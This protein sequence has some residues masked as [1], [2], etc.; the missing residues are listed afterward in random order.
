[1]F[2]IRLK[3]KTPATASLSLTGRMLSHPGCVRDANEDVVAY[4]LPG[5]GDRGMLALVADGM[6]G[7]AAG[8]VASRIAADTVMRMY[9]QLDGS[10]PEVFAA[11]L[12]E[13]NR[14]IRERS[15]AEAACAGMGT[16]C[17][18][19]AVRDDTAFLAHIGDSR[20]YL[21][22]DGR[23]RQISEDHSLV[24][25]LVR[26]G[27]IS[28]EEAARSPQRHVI[29]RALGLDPSVK[30]SISRQGLPLQAGDSL[31]LCS[32]GL[33]DLVDDETIA[34]TVARLPAGEACQ[35]LL[36]RALAAGGTD[37]ISVGVFAV[38]RSQ[39][40]PETPRDTAPRA[41]EPP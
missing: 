26:D 12:A 36:D 31:V 29:V 40:A 35:Q 2:R 25:Q 5:A 16:T 14:L 20:A 1:M 4:A 34:S 6:G 7:H 10:P 28:K 9:H 11:C 23:L 15:E 38:V 27:S 41:G 18:V 21:L 24:A 8:E 37:N 17:T 22:R 30:P 3:D 32:D 33:S 39:S 13:A 19:L